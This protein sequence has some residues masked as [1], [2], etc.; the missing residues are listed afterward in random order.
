MWT[1][2]EKKAFVRYKIMEVKCSESDMENARL[3][4]TDSVRSYVLHLLY[5]AIQS[6]RNLP[7]T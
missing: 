7:P 2:S 1:E 5:V 6:T 3:I 4:L